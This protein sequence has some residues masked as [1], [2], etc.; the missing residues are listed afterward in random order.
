M[1][2]RQIKTQRDLEQV[3]VLAERY[4]LNLPSE[5]TVIVVENNAGE[6]VAFANMRG[7]IMIEPFVSASPQASLHLWK[8]IY[9][10]SRNR[11]VKIL[12]CFAKE[13]DIKLF[14]KLGFYRIFEKNIPME[15]NFYKKQ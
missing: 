8:H 11:G 13:R 9:N 10:E 12:R 5:G 14:T 15:I 3:K 2:I 1:K 7:V 6:I 4:G